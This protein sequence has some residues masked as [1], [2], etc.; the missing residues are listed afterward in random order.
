MTENIKRYVYVYVL[1]GKYLYLIDS[2]VAGSQTQ[3]REYIKSIGRDVTEIKSVFLTH[4]HPDHIGTA[5]WLRENT[6]C[7][8]YAGEKE[9]KWIENIDIQYQERPIPNFYKL[10]GASVKVDHC[11]KDKDKIALEDNCILHAIETPGHS[12]GEISYLVDNSLFIGDC[13][14]V[15]GDI[16]IYV[17]KTEVIESLNKIKAMKYAVR[18]FYPAWDKTYSSENIDIVIENAFDIVNDIEHAVGIAS[19]ENNNI[20]II[21]KKVC[22]ILNKPL[23]EKHPLFTKTIR[24]H[25]E[26]DL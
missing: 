21:V 20:D 5:A 1:E 11:L 10:A 7:T 25:I 8:I 19:Q 16:P 22:Q 24:A 18:N 17:N 3:I 12:F 2:G 13:I 23:L 9:R 4:S 14:P 26:T 6:G 15:K